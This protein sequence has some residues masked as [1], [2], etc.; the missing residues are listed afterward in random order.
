M[1]DIPRGVTAIV[2]GGGKSTLQLVLGRG[3]PA[4]GG[5]ILATTTHFY[6]PACR[7]LTDPTADDIADALMENPV[8][9][10]G[11]YSENG[12]LGPCAVSV[13]DMA[14]LAR[15]VIIEAD[16]ARGRPLKAPAAHEPVIPRETSLVLAV[17]GMDGVGRPI[18]EAAHRPELYAAIVGK[19][20]S[21]AVTPADAAAVLMSAV[22]QRKNVTCAFAAV[23]NK[24]DTPSRLEAAR[25]AAV[26]IDGDVYITALAEGRFIEHWRKG[27]CL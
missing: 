23:L 18:Y 11:S 7:L 19:P 5:V 22:G 21:A 10:V 4:D 1:I 24:A 15:Y 26:L 8:I 25:Q 9:A 6:P 14:R 13:R 3:V 20:V 16:G 2:G 27:I 12:K 17:A